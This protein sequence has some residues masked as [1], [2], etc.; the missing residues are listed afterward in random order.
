V[1]YLELSKRADFNPS[2]TSFFWFL[3]TAKLDPLLL[4]HLYKAILNVR[5]RYVSS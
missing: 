5:I 1:N 4:E 3:D 2:S